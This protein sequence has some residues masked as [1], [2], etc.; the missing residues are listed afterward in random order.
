MAARHVGAGVTPTTRDDLMGVDAMLIAGQPPAP[1]PGDSAMPNIVD[2][3]DAFL[4]RLALRPDYTLPVA[5]R[6]LPAVELAH[7]LWL[8]SF[9]PG[10]RVALLT[11]NGGDRLRSRGLYPDRR[12]DARPPLRMPGL[13]RFDLMALHGLT[14]PA[15]CRV[16]RPRL[17]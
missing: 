9:D 13:P 11:A 16:V 8:V 4:I 2:A 12:V 7:Q 14:P 3:M 6:D 10:R 1:P 17:R 15:G 5:D